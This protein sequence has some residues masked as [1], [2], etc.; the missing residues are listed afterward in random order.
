MDF[1]SELTSPEDLDVRTAAV[2]W[3]TDDE[4][5]ILVTGFSEYEA[6]GLFVCAIFGLVSQLRGDELDDE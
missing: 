4:P 2:I 3:S 1:E 6:I 5:E